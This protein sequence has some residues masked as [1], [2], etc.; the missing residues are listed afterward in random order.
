MTVHRDN[1]ATVATTTYDHQDSSV[2]AEQVREIFAGMRNSGCPVVHSAH[3]GGFSYVNRHEDVRRAMS[4]AG[5]FSSGEN[6][7]AIPETGLPKIPALEFDEPAH[8]MWREVLGAPLTPAAVRAMEP[9]ITEIAHLLIDQFADTGATDLVSS[10]AEPLPAIVIGRMV[11]LNQAEAVEVREL[12]IA[13]FEAMGTAEFPGQMGRFVA[14]TEQRLAERRENPRDDYLSQLARGSVAGVSLDTTGVVGVLTA[15]LLGGHHSTATGIAGLLRHALSEPGVRD[16]LGD[17]KTV[18]RVIEESLR[19]T[20]PLQL[21]ART[22]T[23]DTRIGEHPLAVGERVMLN[24][25]AANRDPEVFPDPERFDAGRQ[26]NPH[27]AFGGGLHTCQ[28]QHLARA[29]LRIALQVLLARLPD[30]RLAGP[31]VEGGMTSGM[32]LPIVSL[33]AVFT[34]E[35]A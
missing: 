15:F 16:L 18:A 22:V 7:I 34:P 33:P 8:S 25:G 11:G 10:F 6:G 12:A 27:V 3:H 28:G 9:T 30:V 29:E 32:L 21:F 2:P 24:L 35:G 4:D 5:S 1:D 14:F 13:M 19:L 23:T 26:R 31:V 17:R 20:T